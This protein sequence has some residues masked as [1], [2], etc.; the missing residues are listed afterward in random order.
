MEQVKVNATEELHDD[1]TGKARGKALMKTVCMAG[2]AVGIACVSY[3][4]GCR[5]TKAAAERAATI[6]ILGAFG[7]ENGTK[8]IKGA[9][10][11]GKKMAKEI[12][13]K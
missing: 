13:K 5:A 1:L 10:E 7:M 4:C 2:A 3:M 6:Q 9:N 11:Y 12:S 8:I